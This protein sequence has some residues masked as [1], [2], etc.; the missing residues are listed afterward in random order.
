VGEFTYVITSITEQRLLMYQAQRVY[1]VLQLRPDVEESENPV[2][3]PEIQGRLALKNV[4]FSYRP[5][6]KVIDGFD[7]EI[8]PGERI[9][10]VG[11]SGIGKSTLF[12]LIGRLYDPDEGEILLDGVSL[13]ELSLG[14][15]R[16]AVGYV[17]QETYLF[18][19]TIRENI[20]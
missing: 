10:L 9:A 14:Q 6:L 16:D 13:R 4:H 15:L 17:F 7:L 2:T 19:T 12:K 1:D 18:G 8:R 3:L 20:R 5:G 11:A